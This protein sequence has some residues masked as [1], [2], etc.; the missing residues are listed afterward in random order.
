MELAVGCKLWYTLE[1]ATGFALLVE[2]AKSEGQMVSDEALVIPGGESNSTYSVFTNPP[3]AKP[4][5]THRYRAG[6]GGNSLRST[7]EPRI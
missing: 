3:D 4:R 1:N 5:C 2:V 7:G 6:T